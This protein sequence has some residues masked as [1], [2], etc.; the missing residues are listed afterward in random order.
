MVACSVKL[1]SYMYVLAF[2]GFKYFH[3]F[4]L[5]FLMHKNQTA[6]CKEVK[7]SHSWALLVLVESHNEKKNHPLVLSMDHVF[8]FCVSPVFLPIHL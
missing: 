2:M 4:L 5:G 1:L 7:I 8:F 3:A 6:C